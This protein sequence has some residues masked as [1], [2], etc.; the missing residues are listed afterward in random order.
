MAK[1]IIACIDSEGTHK[2]ISRVFEAFQKEDV[3]GNFFF[4]GETV[5][6]N[7]SLIQEIAAEHNVDSHTFSH[8]NLRKL[9]KEKQRSEIVKGKE[10]VE[11]AIGRKTIGFRAPYHGINQDTLDILNEENFSY[12]LSALY[13]RR[14]DV[15]NLIE[16]NP[17]WFREWMGFYDMIRMKPPTAWKIFKLL[18]KFCDPLVFPIHPHYS[19]QNDEHSAALANFF[20]L[21]EKSRYENGYCCGIFE[22]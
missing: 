1:H 6:K 11:E 12:D 21:D 8:P 19:G 7:R 13:Y 3:K 22:N 9:P 10:V 20:C 2:Q 14:Y 16:I 15:G 4:V 5:L 18:Y 17:S